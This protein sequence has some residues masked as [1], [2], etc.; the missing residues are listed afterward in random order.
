MSNIITLQRA[1]YERLKPRTV[2][3]AMLE[4]DRRFMIE[5]KESNGTPLK[6]RVIFRELLEDY[7]T[8]LES[9]SMYTLRV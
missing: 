1:S 5:S 7:T 2:D 9:N 3:E 4:L 6:A 8:G